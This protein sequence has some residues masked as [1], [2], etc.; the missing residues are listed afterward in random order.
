MSTTRPPSTLSAARAVLYKELTLER[1]APQTL[2]A[3]ALFCASAFVIF[4]F[5]LG[6]DAIEGALASGVLWVTLT[7]AALLGIG[8]SFV[9][10][11]EEGGLDGFLLAPAPRTALLVAKATTLLIFLLIVGFFASVIFSVLLLGPTPNASQWAS[12]GLLILLADLGI[13]LVGTLIAGIA[14]QT[15][16]RDLITS[17]LALPLLIPLLIAVTKASEPL[18]SV[19]GGTLAWRWLALLGLYDLIFGLLAYALFDYLVE[20]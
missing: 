2:T 3:M 6:R 18:L 11:R 10:D 15:R 20:D 8:R 16:A 13:A 7:L 19:G 12:L 5:A 1:R 9:A 14:I 4:H 17:I